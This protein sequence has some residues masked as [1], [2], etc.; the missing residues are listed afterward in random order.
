[1]HSKLRLVIFGIIF[2]YVSFYTAKIHPTTNILILLEWSL[3]SKLPVLYL[4]LDIINLARRY[5]HY[6]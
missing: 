1:M 3:Y 4:G 2:W 6:I 5:C